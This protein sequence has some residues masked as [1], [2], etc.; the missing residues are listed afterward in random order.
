VV[1][2]LDGDEAGKAAAEEISNRIKHR[3][4]VRRHRT[5]GKAPDRLSSEELIELLVVA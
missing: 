5:S 2:V 1:I 4:F 3:L